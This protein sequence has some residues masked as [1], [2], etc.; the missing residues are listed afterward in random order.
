MHR[1]EE[2]PGLWGSGGQEELQSRSAPEGAQCGSLDPAEFLPVSK[3]QK[4]GSRAG[5][6]LGVGGTRETAGAQEHAIRAWGRTTQQ[7]GLSS[8]RTPHLST[9]T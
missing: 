8:A 6:R 7:R 9:V 4:G 2:L 3:P 5:P 1:L